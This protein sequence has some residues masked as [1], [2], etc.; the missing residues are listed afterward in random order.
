MPLDGEN[1]WRFNLRKGVK[2]QDGS[3]FNAEDVMF[4]YE[5]AS[6]EVAD[7]RSWFALVKDVRIVDDYTIDFVTK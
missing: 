4:S 6:N 7:V 3:A 5:R 2:F 1:G